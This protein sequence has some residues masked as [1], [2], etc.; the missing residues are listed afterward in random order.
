MKHIYKLLYKETL[1]AINTYEPNY[2][3]FLLNVT[4]NLW[5]YNSSS[6]TMDNS[7]YYLRLFKTI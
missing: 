7:F 3:L 4:R 5:K 1:K 2:K 6:Y